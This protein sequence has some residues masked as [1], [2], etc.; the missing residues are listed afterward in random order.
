MIS[1]IVP[2]SS[3]NEIYFSDTI[4]SL[5]KQTFKKFELIIILDGTASINKS[6]LNG[7][8]KLKILSKKKTGVGEARNFGILHSSFDIICFLDSDDIWHKD[9]LK[10]QFNHFKKK[11][12][13]FS[14]TKYKLLNENYERN[15]YQIKKIQDLIVNN[16]ICTSSVM[17]NKKLFSER[18]FSKIKMR[19]DFE[20]WLYLFKKKISLN[21][22]NNYNKNLVCYRKHSNSLSSNKY[23]ATLYHLKVLLYKFNLFFAL[24][25]SIKYI[26]F[27][28]LPLKISKKFIR[29]N[30]K[31]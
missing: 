4:N 20:F 16:P 9:K 2:I 23:V 15:A 26:V 18:R 17:I 14:Y 6:N 5:K 27:N 30:K 8:Y 22:L 12:L 19:S 28:L 1:V 11:K 3:E 13:D 29:L 25:L 7:F 31:I 10:I 21:Y 24:N